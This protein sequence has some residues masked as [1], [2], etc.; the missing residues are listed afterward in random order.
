MNRRILLGITIALITVLTF[1]ACF[2]AVGDLE[3]KE[4][5]TEKTVIAVGSYGGY[6]G[7]NDWF[8]G[9]LSKY[10]TLEQMQ[11]IDKQIQD[12]AGITNYRYNYNIEPG[13]GYYYD[14]E[15][16][17]WRFRGG[18]AGKHYGVLYD[19]GFLIDIETGEVNLTF[20]SRQLAQ[21]ANFA[22]L[23]G[24]K[25]ELQGI[26]YQIV[27]GRNWSPIVLDLDRNDTI[28]TNRNM[29][30]PHAPAFFDERTAF[31]DLT[32]DERPEYCEW[33]G[34]KD[35]L[36]VKPNPD[37]TLSG[38][39]NLFGTAGGYANGY[40]KMAL[41]LDKDE[42][43]L[44]EGDELE[45]LYVWKDENGNAV[46]EKTELIPVQSLGIERISTSHKNFKST[47]YRNGTSISTWDWWPTGF[48]VMKRK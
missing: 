29:W 26:T 5:K 40:E 31:F 19:K 23:V 1:S 7:L 46:C 38:A 11:S 44:V 32:G 27:G 22:R 39:D 42:N 33:L 37:G 16:D 4:E 9:L 18:R 21:G 10:F 43:G 20:S 12:L 6:W 28:D 47:C 48:E 14:P 25:F 36:L 24:K 15:T 45:G 8:K 35:G 30:T 3:R 2:A 17:S 41:T 13:S 34:Q